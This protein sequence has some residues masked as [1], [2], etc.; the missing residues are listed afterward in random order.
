MICA[1]HMA[2]ACYGIEDNLGSLVTPLRHCFNKAESEYLSH[3]PDAYIQVV[4]KYN[5]QDEL[6]HSG[7]SLRL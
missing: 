1:S 3:L 2:A 6:V 7:F 5:E 4:M